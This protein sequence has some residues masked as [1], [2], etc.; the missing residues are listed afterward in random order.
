MSPG[1]PKSDYN[2][3]TMSSSDPIERAE[4]IRAEILERLQSEDR[5]QDPAKLKG[6]AFLEFAATY[7]EE[8]HAEMI[9]TMERDGLSPEEI[10]REVDIIKAQGMW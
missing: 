8:S 10:A 1:P 2:P 6:E 3:G 9:A 7:V 4:A 5:A